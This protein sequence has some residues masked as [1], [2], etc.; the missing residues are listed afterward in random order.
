MNKIMSRILLLGLLIAA[1]AS[2]FIFDLGQYATLDY[3]KQ[4]QADWQ[5]YYQQHKLFV[6]LLFGSV[7]I[8]VTALSLPIATILTLLGGALF[9][10]SFGLLVISFASTMGA[11]LAFLMAR[12]LLRD[13]IQKNY[14]EPLA[15]INAG[16]A[17]E[18]AFYLFA[19]RMVPAFPFFMINIIMGLMPIKAWT[20]FW[21]SQLG[22]L[23]GTAVYVYAGT[24]LGQIES[25][26]GIASW[27]L[28]LA[29]ALL[30]IFPLLARQLVKLIR[31]RKENGAI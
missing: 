1:F 23:P 31:E 13:Y 15:K 14:R 22:M 27:P 18:G 5:S 28:L 3:I 10:L 26:S 30:G 21:V 6:L 24:Q 19:L 8:V 2:F 20:F 12:F 17:Q 16:I 29:F 4:Q 9:G 11:T 7:Y 25:L